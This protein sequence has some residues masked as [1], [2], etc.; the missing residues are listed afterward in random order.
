MLDLLKKV[1]KDVSTLTNGTD[2]DSG[3]LMGWAGLLTFVGLSVY[4]VVWNH[5]HFDPVSWGTGFAA[6]IA[7]IAANLLIKHKTEPTQ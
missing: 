5:G 4:E 2:Y 7:G 3:K 1:I 6:L